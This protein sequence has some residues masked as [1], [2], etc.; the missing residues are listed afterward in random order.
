MKDPKATRNMCGCVIL[1]ERERGIES[2]C[3]CMA[4]W[5]D[6][7]S[8]LAGG[9]ATGLLALLLYCYCFTSDTKVVAG[10]FTSLLALLSSKTKAHHLD[11]SRR[12]HG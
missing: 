1:R 10:G 5:N 6:S 2:V 9:C 4:Q 3:L 7:I 8:K 12:C 11:S